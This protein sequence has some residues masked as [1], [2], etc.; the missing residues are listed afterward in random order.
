MKRYL[1]LILALIFT[2]SVSIGAF[3]FPSTPYNDTMRILSPPLWMSNTLTDSEA[4]P[5]ALNS[6]ML[7]KESMGYS[8]A[9]G[10]NQKFTNL[11]DG[12]SI[13]LPADMK[14][15]LSYSDIC[16]TF[17]NQHLSLKIFK[18]RFNTK[19]ERTAY[20]SYSNKFIENTADHKLELKQSYKLNGHEYKILQWSRRKLPAVANDKNYYACV[21]VLIESRVYTFFFS[22]DI[23]FYSLGGY[24]NIVDSLIT[25][26]PTVAKENAYNKGYGKSHIS[27]MSPSAQADYHYLFDDEN[28]IKFGLF[29]P[30][31]YG[32]YE[33]LEEFENSIDYT[34]SAFLE[35]SEVPDLHGLDAFQYKEKLDRYI[36]RLKTHLDYAVESGKCLELTL[37]TPLSRGT[38]S[39]MVYEILEGKYDAYLT[40]YINTIK[41]YPNVTVLFRPFNEMNGDWCNYSAFHTSRD[42]QIYVELYR[43]L[44]NKFKA[45]GCNNVIWVWNPNEKSFPDFKWNNEVLYYPGD[46]YVDVYG[47]TGYNTGDYY[48]GENWRSFDEIY[49]PIYEKALKINKKPIMITEFSCSSIGGDKIKWIDDMF[50]SLPNYSNIK[51]AIW[52]NAADYDGDVISRSYFIDT[53]NGTLDV[54]KKYLGKE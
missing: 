41:S 43:Y 49:I 8:E 20:L 24:M 37:Q 14:V 30:N 29:S 3:A 45:S 1:S 50:T 15:D 21:D 2:L 42:P 51:L 46:E 52:W 6:G 23:D 18:E 31:L 26:N 4:I 36:S 40:E 11:L 38:S 7:S 53:P 54:F 10:K 25:F 13:I 17:T 16:T 12:Y 9:I 33:K 48:S 39:N 19:D 22:S 27:H 47:I 35:Y 32:G 44:Y 5:I 34:F 28:D